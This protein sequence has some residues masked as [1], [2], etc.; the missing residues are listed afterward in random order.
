MEG[1]G[2]YAVGQLRSCLLDLRKKQ[3]DW[4]AVLCM[5]T[6]DFV[7]CA[8]LEQFVECRSSAEK[9]KVWPV[10]YPLF[11]EF[12]IERKIPWTQAAWP[13]RNR[14]KESVCKAE[15]PDFTT[16][17]NLSIAEKNP[18]D[19]LKWYDLQCTILHQN[20]C[21][22]DKVA[23]A[24]RDFAPERSLALWKKLAEEQIALVNSKAYVKAAVFLRKAGKLMREQGM[25]AEWDGYIQSLR[26]EHR[27]KTR[28]MQVLDSLSP[29]VK[30]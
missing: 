8:S 12:L 26:N 25:T 29:A 28:L 7:R 4:D 15:H 23:E 11:M 21:N 19:A 3:N 13:C 9:L 17:I 20:G 6:E 18:A 5:Q 16:L 27:R 14:G 10:L 24:V 22:A 2:P 30:S 1:K